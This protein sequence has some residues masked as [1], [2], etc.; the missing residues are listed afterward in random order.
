M[1]KRLKLAGKIAA[2][3]GGVLLI[4]VILGTIAVWNMFSVRG[5]SEKLAQEYV[6]EVKIATALRGAA[7]RVMYEIR[8]YGFTE[9]DQYYREG[10]KELD[11]VQNHLQEAKD[12][13]KRA[14]HLKAL[15]GQ[16]EIAEKAKS[17]YEDLVGQT[18][19]LTGELAKERKNLDDAAARYMENCN[20]FLEGQ[21]QRMKSEARAGAGYAALAERLEK[22]TLVNDIIDI[23]N[24]TRIGAWRSQ[25]TRDPA[26]MTEAMSNFEG[27]DKL[28]RDLRAIT[29]LDVDIQ[30][31]ENTEKAAED[32]KHAMTAF[33]TEWKKL[34]QVGS[35][36]EIAGRELIDACIT[37]A[38]A[39]IENTVEIADNAQNSLAASST[40]MLIGL[41]IA[42]VAGVLL[43]VVITV[44]ITGPIN[45][46]INGLSQSGEQVASA[47]EQLSSSSQQMSEGASEQASSLEEVSSSLEEMA[48]MTKQNAD[49]ARQA[50]NMS[51]EARTASTQSKEAM[52]R[53]A[54]AI[55][56][57]KT[58]SDETAKIIK[59]IDE[60]A[61]QTNLLAL[62]AAVEAARAG[63]AGRGFAVVAEEVRNLAQRSAEA[64]KNTAD[65]IEGSQKNAENGVA[66]SDEVGKSLDQITDS[67][68][69]VAQLVGEV[70]A[71]S[72]EQSQGIDQVNTAVA[73]MDKVTQQN[74]ANAEESASASEELS[75]QAQSLSA[76][77]AQLVELVGSK[78]RES[79]Q[80]LGGVRNQRK[81]G[82]GSNHKASALIG[83]RRTPASHPAHVG[84]TA[85]QKSPHEVIPLDDD[86]EL[87]DF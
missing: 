32:Y 33:L 11:A 44:S 42:L 19:K 41:F 10:L 63:E 36:R 2:G 4:T 58:S 61:M 65:L 40:V 86:K 52:V 7:N 8:G 49:N 71:A 15:E 37:T 1:F 67:I 77:V 38:D 43:A 83:D 54:E 27:M 12:L 76:M 85:K 31:I 3:F 75:S 81:Q 62:N 5:D 60:I 55:G 29:R 45:R 16:I 79:D 84:T 47:S 22:I 13:S 66:A 56:K 64:A 82:F 17:K 74:A 68:Q 35:E 39:G 73:Q 6:P 70:S 21:N 9:E 28:F 20:D 25:A 59:T 53:M 46:I 23:G 48:S 57:I 80:L 78:S 34:Q 72:D 30:R 18:V 24:A 14:K 51:G 87:S 50:N 26:V 69:K